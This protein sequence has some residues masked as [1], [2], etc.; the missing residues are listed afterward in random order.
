[1]E[2]TVAEHVCARPAAGSGFHDPAEYA[3]VA[4]DGHEPARRPKR[5][6]APGIRVLSEPGVGSDELI[7]L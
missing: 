3:R 5:E 7:E 4:A 2:Q 6:A 1:M